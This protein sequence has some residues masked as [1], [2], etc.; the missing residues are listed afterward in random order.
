MFSCFSWKLLSFKFSFWLHSNFLFPE[1][2]F[3]L[4]LVFSTIY[5]FKAK[6][7]KIG[8]L[9]SLFAFLILQ[10]LLRM[11]SLFKTI[12][13][14]RSLNVSILK[15]ELD[16]NGVLC[17]SKYRKAFNATFFCRFKNR[18]QQWRTLKLEIILET[19]KFAE[20]QSK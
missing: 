13:L 9:E 10:F 7:M 11:F 15:R 12:L 19:L 8:R 4:F 17:A 1:V 14:L 2:S 18:I 20:K 5:V 3:L 16:N 6:R